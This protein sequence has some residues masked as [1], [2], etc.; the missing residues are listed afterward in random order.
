M[1]RTKNAR[2]MQLVRGGSSYCSSSD[3]RVTFGLG[4]ESQIESLEI[5]WLNGQRQKFGSLKAN[6]F[7]WIRQGQKPQRDP[8]IKG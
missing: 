4:N 5:R 6:S 8:R 7:Y 1:I 3:R 2:Q